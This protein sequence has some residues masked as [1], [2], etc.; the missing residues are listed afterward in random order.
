MQALHMTETEGIGLE[1]RGQFTTR[2]LVISCC[3]FKKSVCVQG[4]FFFYV[5]S[6]LCLREDGEEPLLCIKEEEALT[7]LAIFLAKFK[8]LV[9]FSFFLFMVF[10]K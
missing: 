7:K 9:M 1:F 8:D 2:F 10:E 3:L 4:R 5:G 6:Y